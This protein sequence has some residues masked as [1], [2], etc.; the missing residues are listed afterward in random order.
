MEGQLL[1]APCSQPKSIL[2]LGCG[3]AVWTAAV[4]RQFP[5]AHVIGVD[6]TPPVTETFVTAD[7]EKE[8]NAK[9]GMQDSYDLMSLRVLVS[10]IS[11]WQSLINR[12]FQHLKA[13]GWIENPDITVGTFSETFDW[14]DESSPLMRWY[15]CYRRGAAKNGIDGF[16][17]ER[18]AECLSNAGFTS[19]SAKFYT[20]YLD[21]GAIQDVRDKKIARFTGQNML[22]LLDAVTKV[23]E[24]KG[25]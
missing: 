20:C 16:A 22:G 23:M 24:A 9:F 18:R 15:Q 8:W 21:T 12:C 6:I 17:N 10:A 14:R 25:D 4:A 2:D 7:V 19:V 13:G 3:T 5:G 11:H 1:T